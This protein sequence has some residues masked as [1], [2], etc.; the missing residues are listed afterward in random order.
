MF[1]TFVPGGPSLAEPMRRLTAGACDG[2]TRHE[3]VKLLLW[4]H[5]LLLTVRCVGGAV[6]C[7]GLG[8][9]PCDGRETCPV[10]AMGFVQGVV[11][12]VGLD[13]QLN[14]LASGRRVLG[15]GRTES[16]LV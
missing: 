9:M 7:Q 13:A 15:V 11:S 10:V 6:R 16:P 14:G 8:V 12:T 5:R 4:C 2:T 1:G 3:A